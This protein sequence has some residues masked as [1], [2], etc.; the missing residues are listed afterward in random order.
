MCCVVQ[1]K[2]QWLKQDYFSLWSD[3]NEERWWLSP[4]VCQDFLVLACFL[5]LYV[6]KVII[7]IC[8]SQVCL[9]IGV[10]CECECSF[11]FKTLCMF[12]SLLRLWVEAF[13]TLTGL[14]QFSTTW[15]RSEIFIALWVTTA[16]MSQ[17]LKVPRQNTNV[18]QC[19]LYVVVIKRR[20]IINK[21][22]KQMQTC[23][24]LRCPDSVLPYRQY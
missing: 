11:I 10:Q 6:H 20:A 24:V 5:S 8:M 7:A 17:S 14:T 12:P 23:T 3:G 13:H 18:W 15:S 22:T 2:K 1:W 21:L 4:G 9:V 19:F 16:E